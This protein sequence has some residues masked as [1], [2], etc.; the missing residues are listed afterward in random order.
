LS[1]RSGT[2][3]RFNA[4]SFSLRYGPPILLAT[5]TVGAL[6]SP[7]SPCTLFRPVHNDA[8]SGFAKWF[9]GGGQKETNSI[10][11]KDAEDKMNEPG[12]TGSGQQDPPPQTRIA[13]DKKGDK[14]GEDTFSPWQGFTSTLA[15]ASNSFSSLGDTIADYVIPKWAKT[16]PGYITKI[17]NELSMAPGTLAEQIWHEAN[18]PEINPEIIWEATVRVSDQLCDDEKKFLEK[19]RTFTKRA[20]ARYLD[21]PEGKIHPDDVPVIGMCGSGGGLRALVAGTSS[22]LSAA[23]QGL[24]DCV[25]YTAGVSGSCWLQTLYYSNV[26]QQNHGE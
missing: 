21:I 24:F 9:K 11:T 2:Q 25:T 6:Y 15:S 4:T 23:E 18:D 14:K 8:P 1:T 17:Q 20:L 7:Y 5:A 13:S 12:D 10:S 3:N 26:T 19:R 22:Y 16:L